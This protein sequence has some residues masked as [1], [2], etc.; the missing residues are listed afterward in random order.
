MNDIFPRSYCW[1][2]QLVLNARARRKFLLNRNTRWHGQK[3]A[4]R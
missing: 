3:D 1:P 4:R 2:S